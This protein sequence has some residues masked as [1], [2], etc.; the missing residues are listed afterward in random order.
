MH[1]K[2]IRVRITSGRRVL[3]YKGPPSL[4][5]TGSVPNWKS[6]CRKM[7]LFRQFLPTWAIVLSFDTKS[8]GPNSQTPPLPEKCLPDETPIGNFVEIEG[9]P[10]WIDHTARLLDFSSN[11]YIKRSYG[12]LYL[13]D[14]RERKIR[15]TRHGF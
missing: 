11:D 1:G 5:N 9:T 13:A 12:Y 10:R 7:L 2:L 15:P 6:I 4:A 8:S 3:M 14:C